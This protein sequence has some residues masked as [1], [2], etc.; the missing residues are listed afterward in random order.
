MASPTVSFSNITIASQSTPKTVTTS[1]TAIL[2][3]IAYAVAYIQNDAN[4]VTSVTCD[5]VTGDFKTRITGSGIYAFWGAFTGSTA[6]PTFT[7]N[8]GGSVSTVLFVSVI[9]GCG[10]R[11]APFDHNAAF[12]T[13]TTGNNASYTTS[14]PDD[15]LVWDGVNQAA[16]APTAPTGW[17]TVQS[18]NYFNIASQ[19]FAVLSQSATVS[20]LAPVGT[21]TIDRVL[22]DA[23]T[24]NAPFTARRRARPPPPRGGL[25][26]GSGIPFRPAAF[27]GGT[28]PFPT[29]AG[30]IRGAP[31]G[32]QPAPLA[33]LPALAMFDAA[34]KVWVRQVAETTNAILEGKLNATLEVT[35]T[36]SVASTTVVDVRISAYSVLLFTPLTANAAT[37]LASGALYVSVRKKGE[38]TIVHTNNA[39][40]DR[41]FNMLIIG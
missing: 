29:P 10:N 20:G 27:R 3:D 18:N 23:F 36:A 4:P 40:T 22:V 16:S 38:A 2:G 21:G 9:S 34:S 25:G 39:Q 17:T 24:G 7:F 5:G 14:N 15:L 33:G 32:F 1:G 30:T 11:A 28:A 19:T 26:V 13:I 12:P 31:I 8:F 37:E 35:L 41:E 6:N